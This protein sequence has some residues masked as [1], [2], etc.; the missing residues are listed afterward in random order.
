[1]N[2]EFIYLSMFVSVTDLGY[3]FATYKI[4]K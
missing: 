3:K 4:K 1:M 2:K